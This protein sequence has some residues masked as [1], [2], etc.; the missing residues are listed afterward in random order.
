MKPI[1]QHY[2]FFLPFVPLL[3]DLPPFLSFFGAATGYYFFGGFD[4]SRPPFFLI[5][6]SFLDDAPRLV[7]G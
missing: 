2:H 7:A 1:N 4:A 5:S 6:M 3:F